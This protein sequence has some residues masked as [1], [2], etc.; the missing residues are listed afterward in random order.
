[1]NEVVVK[2]DDTIV[3]SPRD[4]EMIG[5]IS[6]G[7]RFYEVAHRFGLSKRTIELHVNRLRDQ[8]NCKTVSQL[9]S[10]FIRKGL[11]K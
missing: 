8:F 6:N 9:C 10:E 5:Y 7:D 3:I 2:R 4:I 11:I 1:M